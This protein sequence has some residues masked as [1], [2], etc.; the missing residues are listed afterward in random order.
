[1]AGQHLYNTWSP[2]YKGTLITLSNGDLT[3]ASTGEGTVIA[4]YGKSSG[5]WQVEHTI[6]AIGSGLSFG[7]AYQAVELNH[8]TL[9][10]QNIW[11]LGYNSLRSNNATSTSFGTAPANDFTTGDVVGVVC[12]PTGR[13][14]FYRNG[15]LLTGNAE[16]GE[17]G[18]IMY[19]SYG[20]MVGTVYPAFRAYT[21][22][23][24]QI[25]TDFSGMPGPTT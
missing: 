2:T 21:G 19:P 8:E 18:N 5:E 1:M 20:P 10:V 23:G 14:E 7:V 3:A 15:T 22:G 9:F 25:T 17:E 12:T 4:V 13:L 11:T 24:Q 6:D 16:P